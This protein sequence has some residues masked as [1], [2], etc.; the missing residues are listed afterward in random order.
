MSRLVYTYLIK[1]NFDKSKP[2][3]DLVGLIENSNHTWLRI[4]IDLEF[5]K[6]SVAIKIQ[7]ANPDR[8]RKAII[9]QVKNNW[10]YLL[11]LLNDFFK[12]QKGYQQ[13]ESVIE[14]NNRNVMD[15][16]FEIDLDLKPIS[17]KE[18]E[19][20]IINPL[21]N[22]LKEEIHKDT[23]IHNAYFDFNR[24][25]SVVDLDEVNQKSW[26]KFLKQQQ[27]INSR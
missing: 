12:T 6:N 24:Q 14:I 5:S 15:F 23:W 17:P 10:Q 1:T 11:D 4:Q 26:E 22:M 3:D 25:S 18:T 20:K 16:V 7:N 9:E 21:L 19:N 27:T 13:I 2:C 8:I